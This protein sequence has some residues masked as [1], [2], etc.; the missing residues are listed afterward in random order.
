MKIAYIYM[1]VDKK[2]WIL[3]ILNYYKFYYFIIKI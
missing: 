2:N 1:I 3:K